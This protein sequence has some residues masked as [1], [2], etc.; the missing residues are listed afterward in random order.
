[1][2]ILTEFLLMLPFD[3]ILDISANG[4][5]HFSDIFL[6][7]NKG[8]GSPLTNVRNGSEHIDCTPPDYI[9][10]GSIDRPLLPLHIASN[11][12]PTTLNNT[13]DKLACLKVK[14]LQLLS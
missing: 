2:F 11:T 7:L 5:L 6:H 4:H 10:P 14:I 8:N 3:E 1:M 12:N 13:K 9:M